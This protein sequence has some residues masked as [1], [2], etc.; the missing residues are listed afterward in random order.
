MHA[1]LCGTAAAVQQR[2]P[3]PHPTCVSTSAIMNGMADLLRGRGTNLTATSLPLASSL[4][5]YVVPLP[6]L[7][8][9]YSTSKMPAAVM[10]A[11]MGVNSA[12]GLRGTHGGLHGITFVA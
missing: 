5:R 8:S 11:K 6:P 2:A 3:P 1:F 12:R 7:P 10:T 9:S 4:H